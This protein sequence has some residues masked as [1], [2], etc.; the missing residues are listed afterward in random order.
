ML[1]DLEAT[2]EERPAPESFDAI[3]RRDLS[4][5]PWWGPDAV[6]NMGAAG[7]YRGRDEIVAYFQELLE[8]MP[9]FII[10]PERTLVDGSV[11]VVQWNATGTFDGEPFQG[12]EP[13]G[14]RVTTRGVDVMEWE[15]GRIKTNTVYSD[16]AELARQ[17]GLL[18]PADSLAERAMR[19]LFN[20]ATR[21]RR[22]IT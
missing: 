10:E 5:A 14:R 7:V 15:D 6:Y 8:A 22:R 16:S 1:S 4:H 11:T 21:L 9:D 17:I 18:P 12:I 2:W 19:G 20:T 3:N 13:T